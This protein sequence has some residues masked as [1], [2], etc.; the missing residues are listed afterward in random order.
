MLVNLKTLHVKDN[1]LA[2]TRGLGTFIGLEELN[3]GRN[4]LT[5]VSMFGS[6]S[7]DR[8][9]VLWLAENQITD[10]ACLGNLPRLSFL[11][12]QK[13]PINATDIAALQG[14]SSKSSRFS[15]Q[16]ATTVLTV[17]LSRRI[18]V[19]FSFFQRGHSE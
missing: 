3:V 16:S 10:V 1:K 11:D 15:V 8:L 12:L 19:F 4:E 13:N 2:T 14:D 9:E 17:Q 18:G 5:N 7:F 6:G